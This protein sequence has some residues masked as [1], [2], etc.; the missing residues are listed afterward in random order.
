MNFT[1]HGMDLSTPRLTTGLSLKAENISATNSPTPSSSISNTQNPKFTK[2]DQRFIRIAEEV[3]LWSKDPSTKVGCVLVRDRRILTSGYNGLPAGILDDPSRYEDREFKLS[4]VIHAEQ[5]AYL[6]AV[7]TGTSTEG[8]TLY[9]TFPP[10]S[11]CAAST[12]QAGVKKVICPNPM[13]AP[14]RWRENFLRAADLFSEAGIPTLH[15]DG[16]DL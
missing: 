9:V 3:C 15:Y 16:T 8:S 2:W 14:E 5:N 13:L 12:I 4:V 11:H 6:N 7:K 1:L 10:C